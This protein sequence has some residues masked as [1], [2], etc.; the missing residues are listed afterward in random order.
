M[1][2]YFLTQSPPLSLSLSLDLNL[3]GGYKVLFVCEQEYHRDLLEQRKAAVMAATRP[4][5]IELSK[6]HADV[7]VNA[8][9]P[10]PSYI[11]PTRVTANKAHGRHRRGGRRKMGSRPAAKN[12]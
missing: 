10:T 3:C 4:L 7:G 11:G 8:P 1:H 12:T 5:S 2:V 9:P 6:P